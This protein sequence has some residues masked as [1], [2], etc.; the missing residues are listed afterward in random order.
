MR[1]EIGRQKHEENKEKNNYVR[2]YPGALNISDLVL[3][4]KEGERG[5]KVRK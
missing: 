4:G 2:A 5:G 1:E 3:V